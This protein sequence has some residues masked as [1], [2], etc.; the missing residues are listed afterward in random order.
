[1]ETA[2]CELNRLLYKCTHLEQLVNPYE[3][4]MN[5]LGSYVTDKEVAERRVS[6]GDGGKGK[7]VGECWVRRGL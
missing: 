5:S 4:S 6:G 7:Q 2:D 1:V 3:L